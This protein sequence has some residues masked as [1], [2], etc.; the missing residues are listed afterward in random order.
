MLW[1]VYQQELDPL[2]NRFLSTFFAALPVVVLFW[3]LVPRRW[4]AP[5]AGAAGAL[6][7]W[8]VAVLGLAVWSF[9]RREI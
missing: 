8:L 4:L 9:R 6:A 3:L 1:A 7:A 5:K 2:H